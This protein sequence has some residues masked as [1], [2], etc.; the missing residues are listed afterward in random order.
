[1]GWPNWFGLNLAWSNRLDL[2]EPGKTPARPLPLSHPSHMHAQGHRPH[3]SSLSRPPRPCGG[4]ARS[5]PLLANPDT[6]V[7][8]IL[9]SSMISTTS[10]WLIWPLWSQAVGPPPK[11]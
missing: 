3:L 9:L 2:V 8:G 11:P 5:R 6:G 4:T 7:M 1:M 10:P